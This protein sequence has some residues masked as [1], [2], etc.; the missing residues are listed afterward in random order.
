MYIYNLIYLIF[1]G[2]LTKSGKKKSSLNIIKAFLQLPKSKKSL[3]I[4]LLNLIIPIKR[5]NLNNKSLSYNL[6]HF[7][8]SLSSAITLLTK[9]S[10]YKETKKIPFYKLLYLECQNIEKKNSFI[11]NLNKNYLKKLVNNIN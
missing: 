3:Y 1:I 11:Y 7:Y 6:I 9:K 4:I 8:M 5:Q 10:F 2:K